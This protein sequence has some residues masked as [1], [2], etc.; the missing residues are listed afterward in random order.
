MA[1]WL[2]DV[3]YGSV[4]RHDLEFL[5]NFCSFAL[6]WGFWRLTRLFELLK[7]IMHFALAMAANFLLQF[8]GIVALHD[9]DL[10][11]QER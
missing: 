2:P 9:V 11:D 1:S 3:P 10:A 7:R 5:Q 4:T 6:R 8:N